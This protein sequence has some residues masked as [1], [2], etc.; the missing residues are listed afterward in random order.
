MTAIPSVVANVPGG[1]ENVQSLHIKTSQSV[2][3]P[4]WSCDLVTGERWKN[5][6][7]A[8]DCKVM[9][10]TGKRRRDDTPKGDERMPPEKKVRPPRGT[11]T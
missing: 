2:S 11:E 5:I 4:I 10:L 9:A 7:S 6:V 3:L 8:K 1:W